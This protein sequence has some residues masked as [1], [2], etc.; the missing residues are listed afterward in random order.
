[1]G[2]R[3]DGSRERRQFTYS[4]LAEARKELRRITTE[5]EA[6]TYVRRD[7]TTL[8]A[9]LT[10]WLDGRRDVRPNTLEGYRHA[11]VPVIDRLGAMPL[12]QLRT[13]DLDALITERMSGGQPVV[14]HGQRGRASAAVLTWLRTRPERTATYAEVFAEFGKSGEGVLVRLVAD[15]SVT[16]PARGRYQAVPTN[17]AGPKVSGGVSA[18][19]VATMLT[20]LGA[21]LDDALAQGLVVR[22]VAKLVKRP[23]V[24]A[25]EMSAWTDDEAAA[26]RAHITTDR[27][28]ACWLLTLAGFRRSEVLGLRWA[29]VDLAAGTVSV[30]QGRVVVTG[31]TATGEPKSG[32]SKRTLPMPA[33]V[34]AALR[35][36]K[37][38]QATERLALGGGWPET[39][40]VAVNADGTPIR[41]E[42]YSNTFG[43][44]C[45]AA[46]VRAIRLHDARHTA[47]SQLLEAGW[48]VAA[49]AKWLGHDPAVL[50]RTY[51][52]VTDDA[53]AAL[54][55]ALLGRS[56][57]TGGGER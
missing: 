11:L 1:M 4:T 32:R 30:A 26:F 17:E 14:P 38:A 23:K 49:V 51:A 54:G 48:P 18:R 28:A 7:K 19:T 2:T 33:D 36:L 13:A 57:A 39:G 56:R 50:L 53:L 41:P 20:V 10:A 12:Q 5:V 3:P 43:K 29:D 46:G 31:G 35:A 55:D 45:A 21:A 47:A 16:R 15:G 24:V 9:Y 37:V 44:H 40:L 27:L 52:H 8:A 42:T 34:I 25:V 6:G 22:N